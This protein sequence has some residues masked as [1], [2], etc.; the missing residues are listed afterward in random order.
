MTVVRIEA[1]LCGFPQRNASV[2]GWVF[3][4]LCWHI[5]LFVL[6]WELAML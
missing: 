4:S 1:G 3:L 2:L 6:H 5:F